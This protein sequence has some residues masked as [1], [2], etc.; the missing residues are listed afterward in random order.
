MQDLDILNIAL[1]LIFC[2]ALWGLSIY[3]DKVKSTNWRI[4]WLAP[5]FVCLLLTFMSGF[6]ICMLGV[7]IGVL[8]LTLG[9]V[10]P[11]RKS[12]QLVSLAAAVCMIVSIPVCM[13]SGAYRRIDYA[14]DFKQG[15]NAMKAH[16]AL[17][18]HKQIDW[19]ALYDK[20]LPQFEKVTKSQDKIENEI[21][22]NKFCAEFHDLHVGYASDE[23]TLAEAKKRA[24]GNDFGLVIM[25]LADGK[26]AA[27][28]ADPSLEA[29]GIHNG[30]EIV[31]W[32]GMTPAEADELSDYFRMQNFAD[33]DNR[34]FYNGFYAAGTKDDTATLTYIDDS[35]V[36]KTAEL[37]KI[38]DDYYSRCEKAYQSINRGYEAGHMSVT[39]I[40][41]TTACLRIKSMIFDTASEKEN[42][43]TMQQ[44]IREK[45][46]ALKEEGVKDIVIDIRENNGGSGTMVRAI[47]EIF[48]PEGEHYYSSDPYFDRQ[49]NSYVK[50]SD[51]KWKKAN[52]ITFFGEN[53][54]GDEGRIVV[55][56]TAHSVS[57]A[58]HLTK[59]M[60]A[61]DNTTVIGFTE[62]A[63]SAQGVVMLPLTEGSLAYSMGLMLNEDGSVFIDSGTD[64]QSGN[65]VDIKVPFDDKA[66]TALFDN[67][68]DYL[69]EYSLEY[70]ANMER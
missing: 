2:A 38:S 7:Y 56:V 49:T 52:D 64:F 30:T 53:I 43:A 55:L 14:N 13:F 47:A 48:A 34:I 59:V 9:L 8:I 68:E 33:I 5:G 51:G 62:P 15:F 29:L 20:Y 10:K 58:D 32:N 61:F 4:Y 60:S 6:D 11:K 24:A 66:I 22:W 28:E 26:Y 17:S 39:K 27:V 36:Q 42:H 19:D 54:L 44:E 46:L 16:Y 1:G 18:E 63:G 45:V 57:A 37:S 23:E 3:A 12:R 65:D 31:E 67:D 50:E 41:D 25:S 70:L 40:N 69:L 35:G 21:V